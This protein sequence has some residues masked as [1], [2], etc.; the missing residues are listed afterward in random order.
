MCLTELEKKGVIM[1]IGL[2]EDNET[3]ANALKDILILKKHE[4]YLL[5]KHPLFIKSNEIETLDVLIIDIFLG[6]NYGIN[7]IN[8]LKRM[9]LFLTFIVV[10]ASPNQKIKD[11]LKELNVNYIIEKPFHYEQLDRIL[12]E[13]E[14]YKFIIENFLNDGRME[15]NILLLTKIPEIKIFKSLKKIKI[16]DLENIDFEKMDGTNFYIQIETLNIFN[17]FLIIKKLESLPQ[18]KKLILKTNLNIDELKKS[19]ETNTFLKSLV[20]R[21]CY[22]VSETLNVS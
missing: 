17:N 4:V 9:E 14:E 21:K 19:C 13:I 8:Q 12:K 18:N 11:L 20:L 16:E 10:T 3:F 1:K 6:S 2:I 5:N 22:L 15:K 7:I